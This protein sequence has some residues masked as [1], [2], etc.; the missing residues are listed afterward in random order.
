MVRHSAIGHDWIFLAKDSNS[1]QKPHL[2]AGSK[3]V[4]SEAEAVSRAWA[5]D[6][7]VGGELRHNSSKASRFGAFTMEQKER[8]IPTVACGQAGDPRRR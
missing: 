2:S 5:Q 1:S 4:G 7:L 6:F 3:G 8:I